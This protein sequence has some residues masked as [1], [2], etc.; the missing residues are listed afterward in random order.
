MHDAT[1]AC[2]ECGIFDLIMQ[3]VNL[4]HHQHMS[5][6]YSHAMQIPGESHGCWIILPGCWS[7]VHARSHMHM[8]GH[9]MRFVYG[10]HLLHHAQP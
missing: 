3:L 8:T 10:L 1:S 9:H 5:L 6:L 7:T 2:D 4:M